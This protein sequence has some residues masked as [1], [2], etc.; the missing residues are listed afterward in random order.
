MQLA[1]TSGLIVQR[2]LQQANDLVF[3]ERLED[4][5]PGAR[6]QRGNDFE[7]RILGRGA[8]QTDTALLDIRE[9]RVLLGFVEAMHFID[10]DDGARTVLPRAFGIGHHLLDFLDA[11]K[12]GGELDEVG[13]SHAGDDLGQRGFA[14][15]GRSPEDQRAGIVAL[16]L[17]P[18][19]LAGTEYVFLANKLVQRP[20]A[21]AIGQRTRLVDGIIGRRV[22]WKRLKALISPRKTRRAR[23][24]Q[25]T[26][27]TIPSLSIRTLKL[28]KKPTRIPLRR[29]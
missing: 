28:I 3:G 21:H 1:Q 13:M 23:R 11:A 7:R 15:A 2:P 9:K 19:R 10:E 5:D 24:I 26:L 29:K 20:R 16:D 14:D 25:R 17:H 12:Y 4:V 6:Q 18:Q 27:R 8:D 22:G